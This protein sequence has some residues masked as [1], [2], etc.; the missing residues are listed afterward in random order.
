MNGSTAVRTRLSGRARGERSLGW[1]LS[2]PAVIVLLAVTGYPILQAFYYSLFNYRLT[3]PDNR[4]L[5]WGHNYLVVLTDPLWWQTLGVTLLITV[6]TV[7]I[8]LVLGFALAL[9]MLN[10]LRSVRPWL[11]TA[12]LIPYGIITVVA[13]FSWKYAFDLGT[14]FVGTWTGL[15]DF[16][17]FGD[18]WSAFV[19]ICATEI[20]KTT[21]FISLLLLSGL[22]QISGDM[23]E[24]ATVDGAT[25]W[26][27]MSRVIIP[28]MKAAIMVAL[29]FRTLDAFRIFD[30][31]FVM[32]AGAQSTAT[33]SF[34]TYNQSISQLQI[35]MGSALSV[36]LF[37]SVALICFVFIELF[38]VD[39]AQARGE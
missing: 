3:D 31:V 34:L 1:L 8:E 20:W 37:L 28:N 23:L 38:K 10:A 6:V 7:A 30:S 21:P 27:R 36:L 19:V 17:W 25:W 11:R 29:L 18:F 33:V 35:G 32:T 22:A 13:A 39:L 12:I 24:A 26:Q 14:G 9:V 2:A 15:T 5:N 16:D 4:F